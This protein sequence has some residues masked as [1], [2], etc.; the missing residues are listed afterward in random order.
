MVL[1][2]VTS[3]KDMNF[4]RFWVFK[5]WDQNLEK[6]RKN[7]GY[8]LNPLQLLSPYELNFENLPQKKLKHLEK[9]KMK[10]LRAKEKLMSN[11]VV[12][13]KHLRFIEISKQNISF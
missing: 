9:I 13:H 10:S 1:N 12:Y 6:T 11:S 4:L 5:H 2:V 3:K 8:Q 7:A